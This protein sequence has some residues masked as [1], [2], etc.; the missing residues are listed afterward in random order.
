MGNF[1]LPAML[2]MAIACSVFWLPFSSTFV[3]PRIVLSILILLV[4]SHLA[5]TANEELPAAAPYNW[6]DLM[7]STIQLYMFFVVCLNLF[8]ETVYHSMKCT[9]TAVHISNELRV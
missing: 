8:V 6:I 7:C 2:Y 4:F 1:L 9:V 5:S 3:T